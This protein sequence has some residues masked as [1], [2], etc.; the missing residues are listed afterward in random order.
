MSF[1]IKV[2]SSSGFNVSGTGE[3]AAYGLTAG[4]ANVTPSGFIIESETEPT[5]R[6]NG[7]ALQTGDVW[8]NTTGGTFSFYVEGS[9]FILTTITSATNVSAFPNDAGYISD[10]T[11][12]SADVTQ[13]EADITI[14]QS[15]I[16]DLQS[17]ALASDLST[18]AS[19]ASGGI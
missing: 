16:S 4:H 1:N 10:Y 15:Q 9:G 12:T 13:H 8:F 6:D 17:F 18:V 14:T 7:A 2:G 11:V 5:L 3:S 19:L